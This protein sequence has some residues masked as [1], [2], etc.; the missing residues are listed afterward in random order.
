MI[1]ALL[2]LVWVAVGVHGAFSYGNAYL[3]YRGF[4]PPKDPP[5]VARGRV[6]V[7]HFLSPALR[8]ERSY[9]VYEPPGYA[10]A[11][12]RGKRL[13]VLYLLHGSPGK[14]MTFINIARA[15]V[16]LDEGLHSHRLRPFL[17]VMPDGRNGTFRSETE[18]ANTP[19]GRYES[20]VLETVHQVDAHFATKRKRWFRAIGGNSEGGYAALNI[21]LRHLGTFSI[22]EGWSGYYWEGRYGAF[23]DASPAVVRANDPEVYVRALR[24]RL[25]RF[26]LHAY[27][28]KGDKE[29]RDVKDRARAF[30]AELRAAG[31]HATF[32]LVPGG[33]SWRVW[34]MQTPLML[35]Y[36]SGLFGVRR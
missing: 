2:A 22:A 18:W 20:L 27:M 33:H 16:A 5:G 36:A 34:R 4:P 23:K 6:V 13:P 21:A 8:Q 14:P 29:H 28:Y 9:V 7:R 11:V 1:A 15:G 32:R 26:P 10:R 30:A 24:A 17:I 3:K 25:R 19:N 35:R 12:A 31:G